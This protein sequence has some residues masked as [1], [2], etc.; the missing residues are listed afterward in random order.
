MDFRHE[1]KYI[2]STQQALILK[3]RLETI[4]FR[5]AHAGQS[6]A[7]EIRSIYF[8][9]MND[10]CY[11][12]NEAGTDPRSKYRIR[13]Y[14]GSKDQ[15]VLEK[16]IKQNGMTKKL[17][18]DLTMAQFEMLTGMSVD[19][20]AENFESIESME[21]DLCHIGHQ[22]WNFDEIY[23]EPSL[24]QELLILKQTRLMQPKVI[25]SY[26]R[27]PFVENN[28]NV[29]VTF[30]DGICSSADFGTFFHTDLHARKILPQGQTLMEVKFDEFLP[31][32]IKEVLE[33]G[34]LRQTTF[35]KYYLCRRYHL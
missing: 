19:E 25:V 6:G 28:G 30:D 21:A 1:Y 20:N 11:Y 9:D 14:N 31:A 4:M 29:R 12:Q 15:I 35:S 17:H 2:I 32:Y 27:T 34:H 7:Y 13:I 23:E 24:I 16:K 26:E 33:N 8:D 18:Q 10:S 5:D 3:S 22:L